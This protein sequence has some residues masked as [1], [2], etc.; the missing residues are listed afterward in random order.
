MVT[1]P[2]TS[3]TKPRDQIVYGVI[4]AVAGYAAFA[5]IGAADFLLDGVLVA[6]IWE[7]VR[8]HQAATRAGRT[9]VVSVESVSASRELEW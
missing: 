6:N 7:A 9:V 5:M 8:R 3:P 1:D 4:T 2:P